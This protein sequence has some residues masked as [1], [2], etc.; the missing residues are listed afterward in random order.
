[1]PAVWKI[2]FYK[3][4]TFYNFLNTNS[5]QR[6]AVF[7]DSGQ[8]RLYPFSAGKGVFFIF[9]DSTDRIINRNFEPSITLF[10]CINAL[11]E[12]DVLSSGGEDNFELKSAKLPCSGMVKD[13]FLLRHLKP[14][15]M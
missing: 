13:I 8:R 5:A 7:Y 4:S 14:V 9:G 2:E 6:R 15:W 12:G 3:I 1:M 10:H 11:S